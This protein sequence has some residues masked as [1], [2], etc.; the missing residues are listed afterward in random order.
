MDLWMNCVPINVNNIK[1]HWT[2]HTRLADTYDSI[3]PVVHK[4]NSSIIYVKCD[5]GIILC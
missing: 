4:S 5:P 2:I 1:A 3:H